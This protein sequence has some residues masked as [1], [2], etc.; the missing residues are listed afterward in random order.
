MYYGVMGASHV[1]EG[2]QVG[3]QIIVSSKSEMDGMTQWVFSDVTPD[4]FH[5]Q[6]RKSSDG[7]VTWDV[8]FEL[9][10]RRV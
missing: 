6:N 4:S 7:G 8:V 9:N 2:R 5:W 10:A 1:L 3:E